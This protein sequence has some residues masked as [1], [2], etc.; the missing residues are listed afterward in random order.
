MPKFHSYPTSLLSSHKTANALKSK[1]NHKEHYIANTTQYSAV[2][3]PNH[4][5]NSYQEDPSLH[6]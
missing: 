2:F 5:N 4:P 1:A 3:Q 6:Y